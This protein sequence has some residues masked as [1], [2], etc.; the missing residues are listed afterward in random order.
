MPPLASFDS[1]KWHWRQN[2]VV[3]EADPNGTL[4][5]FGL[6]GPLMKKYFAYVPVALPAIGFPVPTTEY[7]FIE[8]WSWQVVQTT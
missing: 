7:T 3:E 1:P 8:C 5:V 4:T 2:W 6:Y